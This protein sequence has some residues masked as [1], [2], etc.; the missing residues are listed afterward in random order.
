MSLFDQLRKF[1]FNSNQGKGINRVDLKFSMP[2]ERGVL[3]HS[4]TT[5]LLHNFHCACVMRIGRHHH[6]LAGGQKKGTAPLPVGQ[7]FGPEI[8]RG[9]RTGNKIWMLAIEVNAETGFFTPYFVGPA[10]GFI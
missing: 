10:H 7:L 6:A 9:R 2:T 8:R 1:Y 5:V 4:R 3:F